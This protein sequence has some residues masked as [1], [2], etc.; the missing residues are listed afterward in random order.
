[1]KTSHSFLNH[2]LLTLGVIMAT[3]WLLIG[4]TFIGCGSSSATKAAATTTTTAA[5]DASLALTITEPASASISS[6]SGLMK[7]VV[8]LSAITDA[9]PPAGTT[10]TANDTTG[11][12]L[13]NVTCPPT[14]ADGKTTCTG[15]TE[16]QLDAGVVMVAEGTSITH[17]F[18]QIPTATTLANVAAATVPTGDINGNTDFAFAATDA[19]LTEAGATFAS[20]GTIDVNQLNTTTR[21]LADQS[22]DLTATDS[23]KDVAALVLAHKTALIN[24]NDAVAE[25]TAALGGDTTDIVGD[26]GSTVGD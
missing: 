23:T 26:V 1:M 14:D 4:G 21:A 7:G 25:T 15:F 10:V 11:T 13:T 19:A 16:A 6:S 18:I 8:R 2:W 3:N 5:G 24:G 17:S 22:T 9:I 20:P 12:E